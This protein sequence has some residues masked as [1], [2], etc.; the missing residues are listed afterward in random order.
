[1]RG[2]DTIF[3][4][5]SHSLNGM[6]FVMG[7]LFTRYKCEAFVLGGLEEAPPRPCEEAFVPGG[8]STRHKCHYSYWG[9]KYMV[10]IKN[11]ACDISVIL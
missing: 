2:A 8:G 5:S 10:Q 4:K 3:S 9:Q 7:L 11:Q 1:M 6:K